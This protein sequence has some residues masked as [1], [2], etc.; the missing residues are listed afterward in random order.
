MTNG[1]DF[2]YLAVSLSKG[3]TPAELRTATSRAYYGAFHKAKELIE[4]CGIALPVGPE[5]H[6]KL[7]Y[8]LDQAGSPEVA[9]IGAQLWSLRNARNHA[10][11]D[12]SDVRPESRKTV[13]LYLKFADESWRV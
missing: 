13:V 7:R 12:L 10:D 3:S 1:T 11:Y 9:A 2:F 5:C 4:R 8:L 6:V